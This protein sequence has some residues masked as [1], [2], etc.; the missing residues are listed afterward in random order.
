M[1]LMK[2]KSVNVNTLRR[3]P[4]RHPRDEF[5]QFL[6]LI[7]T[8]EFLRGGR[9]SSS[10]PKD[11]NSSCKEGGSE[12]P[13]AMMKLSVELASSPRRYFHHHHPSPGRHVAK[14][15]LRAP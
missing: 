3:A 13:A 6:N 1:S 2:K 11:L 5:M 7:G 10:C 14:Q 15:T 8:E 4:S 12:M 9:S